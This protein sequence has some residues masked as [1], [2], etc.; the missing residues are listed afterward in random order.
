[1]NKEG[2]LQSTKKWI[3]EYQGNNIVKGYAKWFV[4]SKLGAVSELKLLGI[5]IDEEYILKLKKSEEELI[6]QRK[7]KKELTEQKAKQDMLDLGI[8]LDY[9]EKYLENNE[10]DDVNYKC[11]GPDDIENDFDM[12]YKIEKNE[13]IKD[14]DLPF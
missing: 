11:N 4:V 5:E 2:R 8:P 9:Y 3:P 12:D 10:N 13:C 7:I 14:E 1:M 6:K